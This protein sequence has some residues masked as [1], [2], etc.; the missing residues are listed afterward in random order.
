MGFFRKITGHDPI[1]FEPFFS[2]W[3]AQPPN[4]FSGFFFGRIR[5]LLGSVVFMITLGHAIF[6]YTVYVFGILIPKLVEK[7]TPIF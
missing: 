5:K 3:I 4:E 6:S 1:F 2:N 7:M